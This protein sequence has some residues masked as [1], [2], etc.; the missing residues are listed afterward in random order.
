VNRKFRITYDDETSE[1]WW[2]RSKSEV[3]SM[4]RKLIKY[5]KVFGA[6][7]PKRITSVEVCA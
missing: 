4:Q 6:V 5:S 3:Y 1:M 7:R 2:L